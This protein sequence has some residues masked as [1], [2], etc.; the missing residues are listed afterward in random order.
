MSEK[1]LTNNE[2]GIDIWLIGDKARIHKTNEYEYKCMILRRKN[3][4]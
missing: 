4:F 1:N 2:S 3:E